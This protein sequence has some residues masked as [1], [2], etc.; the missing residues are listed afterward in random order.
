MFACW[1]V[2]VLLCLVGET[3]RRNLTAPSGAEAWLG[4]SG[5]CNDRLIWHIERPSE[6][7]VMTQAAA[8]MLCAIS[9]PDL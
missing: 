6:A 7:M 5:F 8:S 2:A 3:Y 4:V 9:M 1:E